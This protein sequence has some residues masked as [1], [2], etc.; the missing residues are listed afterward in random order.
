[1]TGG[2]EQDIERLVNNASAVRPFSSPLQA[3]AQKSLRPF[4][5][6]GGTEPNVIINKFRRAVTDSETEVCFREGK[7][8]INNLMT[9]YSVITGRS[10]DQIE[11]DFAGKGYG[12][13]KA[14]VGSAVAEKLRPI[15]ED[16][17]RFMQDKSVTARRNLFII[18]FGSSRM[19][20]YAFGFGSDLDIF[21]AG[22][23][24]DITRAPPSGR[25]RA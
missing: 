21:F 24:R 6:P 11:R 18:T 23:C 5:P 25:C 9:I 7:D 3:S 17:A 19:E 13:F 4:P 8:G 10:L 20:I 2:M 16:F 14:E 12:D 15:R 1:M 22:S